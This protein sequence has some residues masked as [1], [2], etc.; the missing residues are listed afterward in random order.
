MMHCR[1][2]TSVH[3]GPAGVL[4]L[5]AHVTRPV[6]EV[7]LSDAREFVAEWLEMRPVFQHRLLGQC[8]RPPLQV[9]IDKMCKVLAL[10]LACYVAFR[11]DQLD[12]SLAYAVSS[13][14]LSG[15]KRAKCSEQVCVCV[16]LYVHVC[17]CV[18]TTAVLINV[19]QHHSD[20]TTKGGFSR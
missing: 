12:A 19:C 18:C 9:Q 3:V 15:L 2:A 10:C 8:L 5:P 16:R 6:L 20:G 17:V 13:S 4:A 1:S 7:M 14:S 11:A